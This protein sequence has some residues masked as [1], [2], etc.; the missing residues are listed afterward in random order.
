MVNRAA[1]FVGVKEAA[2]GSEMPV[3]LALHRVLAAMR[4]AGEGAAGFLELHSVMAG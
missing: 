4:L 3:T 1:A 2:D